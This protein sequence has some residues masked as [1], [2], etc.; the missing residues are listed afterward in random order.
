MER[1]LATEK[2]WLRTRL[3]SLIDAA[4][5]TE[6][7]LNRL[8]ALELRLLEA[9]E[10]PAVL[11]ILLEDLKTGFDLDQVALVLC[12]DQNDLQTALESHS[13][14]EHWPLR[15]IADPAPLRPL[16]EPTLGSPGDDDPHV[17]DFCGMKKLSS[18]ALLPLRRGTDPIG[19]LVLGS[20]RA[21][22]YSTDQDTY[23]LKRLAAVVSVCLQNTLSAWR[24][25]E[26]GVTDPLTGMRNRR[27]FDQ[28]LQD[29]ILRMEREGHALA[30]LFVDIDHFKRVNDDHGHATG[31]H[32]ITAVAQRLAHHLRR[33][34]L[35]ARYGGEEFVILLPALEPA[36]IHAV[37]ERMRHQ[38]EATPVPMD[39]EGEIHVTVSIGAARLPPRLLKGK[40]PE[41]RAR[42][43]LNAADQALLQAKES[44]R[45]R[46]V[47]SQEFRDA[48]LT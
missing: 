29:E 32:V 26:I 10:F 31:D 41:Q 46:L 13:L 23:L 28:R 48:R 27:F 22:R 17:L 37:A 15:L 42:A 35:L 16:R 39:Q 30:C 9:H 12:D 18:R 14:P 1:H 44:G 8:A 25:R 7:K 6:Q 47:I 3:E 38:V 5:E 21:E 19:L 11:G 43:L 24:L 36:E 34:D 4:R 33:F 20:C 2:Q 40:P 45:N